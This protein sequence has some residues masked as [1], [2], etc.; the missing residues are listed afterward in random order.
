MCVRSPT[1]ER[2]PTLCAVGLM[3]MVCVCSNLVVV[4]VCR[5]LCVCLQVY[6]ICCNVCVCVYVCAQVY[7]STSDE[8]VRDGGG[9]P[10]GKPGAVYP[11]SF[12]MQGEQAPLLLGLVALRFQEV[13]GVRNSVLVSR[14]F[15]LCRSICKMRTSQMQVCTSVN[16]LERLWCVWEGRVS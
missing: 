14:V 5:G 8:Y 6:I 10:G 13:G 15:R 7:A 4:C 11:G 16:K 1:V 9:Y 3:P 2:K 12:Y